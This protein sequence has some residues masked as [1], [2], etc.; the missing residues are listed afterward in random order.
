MNDKLGNTSVG[1][2]LEAGR[3]NWKFSGEVAQNFDQHIA[4]SVPFY[5]EGHQLICDLSD[6]FLKSGSLCYEFGC[7]T[8]ALTR[9]LAEHTC[10]K[11]EA[12]F[13]GVDVEPDMIAM[14][15]KCAPDY[16]NVSFIADDALSM[17]ME[18]CDLIVC[19]YTVQFIRP[20]ERQR[21]IDKFY[22]HLQWGGALLMFEKVRGADAR[23]QDMMSVIYEDYKLAQ[24]YTPQQIMA[25]SRSLKGILEPFSSQA[26]M[27]MLKRAG[28]VDIMSVMKY[29]CFEGFLAIK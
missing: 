29:V 10:G 28:F 23:F 27:D 6:F 11:T 5:R 9:K 7:S 16:P 12:C 3:V 14:A 15:K 1:D 13:I 18:P 17:E 19:Y 20:S 4:K 21:L 25:K 22:R 8:G 24:G 26:N 2:G